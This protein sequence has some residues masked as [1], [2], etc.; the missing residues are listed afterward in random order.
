MGRLEKISVEE[1]NKYLKYGSLHISD[2][3]AMR[4]SEG[5]NPLIPRQVYEGWGTTLAFFKHPELH[6]AIADKIG[7]DGIREL[8]KVAHREIGTKINLCHMTC[9]DWI[10]ISGRAA[11][12]LGAL[13][14]PGDWVDNALTILSFWKTM[15]QGFRK[16]GR[17]GGWESG[18]VSEILDRDVVEAFSCEVEPLDEEKRALVGRFNA[19]TQLL[20]FLDHFDCRLGLGDTGPYDLGDK[21]VVARDAYVNEE[22]YHWSDACEGLPFCYSLVLTFDKQAMMEDRQKGQLRFFSMYDTGTIFSDPFDHSKYLLGA[23][24]YMR[25]KWDT[26]M[27]E[28]RRLEIADL[29]HHVSRINE[30]ISRLYRKL[31]KMSEAEKMIAGGFVYSGYILPILRAAGMYEE[32]CEKYLY[33]SVPPKNFELVVH[34][35]EMELQELI[36]FQRK[37]VSGFG[38]PPIPLPACQPKTTKKRF[39]WSYQE[40]DVNETF[41][42]PDQLEE[43]LN[44]NTQYYLKCQSGFYGNTVALIV[45][46]AGE[47][48]LRY[49]DYYKGSFPPWYTP[50][51]KEKLDMEEL[52]RQPARIKWDWDWTTITAQDFPLRVKECIFMFEPQNPLL[53]F[54][55]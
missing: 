15:M 38:H 32:A 46:E 55:F 20:G 13:C 27:S 6:E 36:E 51:E 7:M 16:D 31:A 1:A 23:A 43:W 37:G 24:A 9:I 14:D 26:P 29:P 28:V 3:L 35:G 39:D 45:E 42:S 21:L 10:A 30:A 5:Y 4:G 18:Y 50:E 53:P 11:Q 25:E 54:L 48:R 40:L 49:V 52:A 12:L 22:V 47:Q 19:A 17:L 44:R 33:W 34:V 8:G 41:S 2:T